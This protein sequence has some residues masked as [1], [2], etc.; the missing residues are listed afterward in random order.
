[1]WE[2]GKT[3]WYNITG[4][5]TRDK[6]RKWVFYEYKEFCLFIFCEKDC[7]NKVKIL[8]YI[9]EKKNHLAVLCAQWKARQTK[10]SSEKVASVSQ[11]HCLLE[12]AVAVKLELHK[13]ELLEHASVQDIDVNT[14]M[15]KLLQE[16][17][18]EACQSFIPVGSLVRF[19]FWRRFFLPKL[20]S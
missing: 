6:A 14:K 8:Y 7:I 13:E 16:K 10:S 19:L 20:D 11:V 15:L 2:L 4:K 9:D 18:D 17:Q 3:I 1:M 5:K 12:E